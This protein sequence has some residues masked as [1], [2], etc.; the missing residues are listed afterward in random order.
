MAQPWPAWE[1]TVN[2]AIIVAMARSASSR[3]MYADLPPSSRKT[4]FTV[5]L[6][7]AMMRRPVAVEPVKLIM[8]TIGSRDEH[9]A[10]L[11]PTTP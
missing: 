6:A 4:C 7:T 3:T 11:V 10:H 2:A 9:L 5:S 1:H 8:S